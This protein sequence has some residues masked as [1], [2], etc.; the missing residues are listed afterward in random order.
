M[1]DVDPV[2]NNPNHREGDAADVEGWISEIHTFLSQKREE[3]Q[4]LADALRPK[5]SP[6]APKA[7]LAADDAIEPESH[8]DGAETTDRL[9]LLRQQL[10]RRLRDNGHQAASGNGSRGPSDSGADPGSPT[11]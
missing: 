2:S 9:S 11:A 3:I 5:P 6:V 4:A 8:R 1:S 10:E 7:T